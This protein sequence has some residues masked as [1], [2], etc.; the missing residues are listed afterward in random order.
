MIFTSYWPR[1]GGGVRSLG[2]PKAK[3]SHILFA[4]KN[5]KKANEHCIKDTE[6]VS[7]T[8]SYSPLLVEWGKW[9]FTT[10]RQTSYLPNGIAPIQPNHWDGYNVTMQSLSLLPSSIQCIPRGPFIKE[11]CT[12]RCPSLCTVDLCSLWPRFEL[13]YADGSHLTT[14]ICI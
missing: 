5:M 7:F 12:P 3:D 4:P 13:V 14:Y 6:H 1:G 2:G 9:L 8:P 10:A 11:A